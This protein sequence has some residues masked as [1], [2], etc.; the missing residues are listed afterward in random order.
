[1]SSHYQSHIFH[2]PPVLCSSGN[3]IDSCGVDAAVT[4][5][6]GKLGDVLFHS[7]EDTGKQMAKV[8]RKDLFG[9]DVRVFA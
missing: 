5:D 9:I 7:V 2:S 6:V 4:E 3:D 1:M 8:V